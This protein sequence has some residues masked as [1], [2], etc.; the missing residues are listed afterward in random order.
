MNLRSKAAQVAVAGARVGAPNQYRLGGGAPIPGVPPKRV[1]VVGQG[2]GLSSFVHTARHGAVGRGGA[3]GAAAARAV[4]IQPGHAGNS[5]M[6]AMT[7]P[8]PWSTQAGRQANAARY[9]PQ[10]P[11]GRLH[12]ADTENAEGPRTRKS[13]RGETEARRQ[14]GAGSQTGS[15]NSSHKL[16]T[17]TY[18]QRYLGANSLTARQRN[19]ASGTSRLSVSSSASGSGSASDESKSRQR[20]PPRA[21]L[22]EAAQVGLEKWRTKQSNQ[23]NWKGVKRKTAIKQL[24]GSAEE[25]Q[26]SIIGDKS[27]EQKGPGRPKGSRTS[28]PA[29]HYGYRSQSSE[30]ES[31]SQVGE[32]L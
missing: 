4:P 21:G 30:A 9:H 29:P 10:F 20:R 7:M 11:Q 23:A 22:S 19:I 28:Q 32:V 27:K 1:Q 25:E 16:T 5:A 14:R 24:P 6:P 13:Q 31:V 12:T 26:G 15:L 8:A 18:E 17:Q 2:D 3:V